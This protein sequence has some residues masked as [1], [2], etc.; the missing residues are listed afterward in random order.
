MHAGGP[1]KP[2]KFWISPHPNPKDGEVPE[3]TEHSYPVDTGGGMHYEADEVA[4]CVRDGKLESDRMP[5]DESRV[6]Q[7][8]FDQVRT[9]GNTIL[10]DAKGTAGQ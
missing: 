7:G 8:W 10:K 4:R 9:H 2:Q 5:W 6:V 3:K 1:F